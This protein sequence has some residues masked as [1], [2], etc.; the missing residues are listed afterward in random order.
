MTAEEIKRAVASGDYAAATAL[1]NQ[2][3]AAL[4]NGGLTEDSLTQARDLIDS[5][6]PMLRTA[7][8][9]A[10]HHLRALHVAVTYLGT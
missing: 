9:D 4:A 3:T 2:Y 10:L 8:A 5:V 7:H 6:R 1:W